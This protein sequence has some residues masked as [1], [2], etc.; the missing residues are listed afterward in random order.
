MEYTDRLQC[1]VLYDL[2][3]ITKEEHTQPVARHSGQDHPPSG[4]PVM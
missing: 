3:T 4:P 1:L 2:F